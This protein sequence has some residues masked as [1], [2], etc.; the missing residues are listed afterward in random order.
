MITKGDWIYT[1]SSEPIITSEGTSIAMCFDI[2]GDEQIDN[3]KLIAAA[4]K[5]H[6][7][8]KAFIDG[9]THFLGC[10]DFGRSC[11]DSEA[12]RFMNEV[13]GQIETAYK[14]AT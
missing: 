11:F 14:E 12:I 10:I 5:Q 7:A 3:A 2:V 8:A 9:W 13:P 4:P 6:A 1:G